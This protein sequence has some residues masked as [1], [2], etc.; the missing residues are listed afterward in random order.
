M[1]A[2]FGGETAVEHTIRIGRKTKA[3]RPRKAKMALLREV[4]GYG[5]V[6]SWFLP[7]LSRS[8]TIRS[9]PSGSYNV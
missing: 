2:I 5:P 9:I 7:C 3:Q 6:Y 1:K 4:F 8:I